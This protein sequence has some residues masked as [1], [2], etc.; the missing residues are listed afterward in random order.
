MNLSGEEPG[1]I[2]AVGMQNA[3]LALV[4]LESE[5]ESESEVQVEADA[6]I[7]P[8]ASTSLAPPRD[9][10]SGPEDRRQDVRD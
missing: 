3:V 6:R 10:A 5:F 4:L 9:L 8:S 7:L 1:C 2:V